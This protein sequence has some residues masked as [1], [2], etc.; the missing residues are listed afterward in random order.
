MKYIVLI[1][2]SIT[3][4]STKTKQLF[5]DNLHQDPYI[6]FKKTK[7]KSLDDFE[8]ADKKMPKFVSGC[9]SPLMNLNLQIINLVVI[10]VPLIQKPGTRIQK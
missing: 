5:C 3:A 7:K 1:S 6:I 8:I 9:T 2:N 10:V 4:W